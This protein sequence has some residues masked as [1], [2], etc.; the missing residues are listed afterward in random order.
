MAMKFQSMVYLRP[1]GRAW[2]HPVF[3]ARSEHVRRFFELG[4]SSFTRVLHTNLFTESAGLFFLSILFKPTGGGLM[5]LRF[6]PHWHWCG[7]LRSSSRRNL[8]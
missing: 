2:T 6:P 7:E 8:T 3:A 5:D 1:V 4:M